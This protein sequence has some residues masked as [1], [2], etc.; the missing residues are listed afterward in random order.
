VLKRNV[1]TNIKIVVKT[2]T[3]SSIAIEEE[4]N[5]MSNENVEWTINEQP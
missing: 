1:M 2:P 5:E 4:G 3:P